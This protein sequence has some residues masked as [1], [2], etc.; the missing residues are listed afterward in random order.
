MGMDSSEARQGSW[1]D[2][3]RSDRG[4]TPVPKMSLVQCRSTLWWLMLAMTIGVAAMNLRFIWI[5]IHG[6]MHRAVD[7][8][9]RDRFKLYLH[10]STAPFILIAGALLHNRNLRERAPKVHRW[11]GR[12]YLTLIMLTAPATFIMAL[13]ETEGIMTVWS[14][15]ILSVLWFATG[16]M[17]W[18][19]AVKRN[20]PVHSQWMVRNYALTFTNVTFRAELHLLLAFGMPLATVYE[21]IRIFQMIPNLLVAELLIRSGFLTATSWSDLH[22]NWRPGLIVQSDQ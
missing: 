16:T 7:H 19:H 17:A 10:L 15:A 12:I 1:L 4:G 3:D 22:W 2:N 13:R 21:P 11:G 6:I 5:D 8:L 18:Y 14:F 9:E 20:F